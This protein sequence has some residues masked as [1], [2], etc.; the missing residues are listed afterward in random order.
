MTL[1]ISDHLKL[2]LGAVTEPLA[3]VARRGRGK[4]YAGSVLA[5]EMLKV[6]QQVAVIDPMDVWFGLRS[7]ADGKGD[8]FPVVI[9]GGDHGD[10]AL[11]P[12]MGK[13]VADFL[14]G[15]EISAVIVPD[16]ETNQDVVDF[17]TAFLDRLLKQNREPLHLFFDEAEAFAPERPAKYETRMLGAMGRLIKRGRVRGLGAT[18]ITQRTASINKNVLSQA[19][20]L[21]IMALSSPWDRAPVEKWMASNGTP[22]QMEELKDDLASLPIGGGYFWHPDWDIFQRIKIR[23]R[24]TFDSSATPEPGQKQ[25]APKKL[26][27]IDREKV[28]RQFAQAVERAKADDPEEL[29]R[30][31]A[32][33]ERKLR[34]VPKGKT[35]TE[36]VEIPV[37][38]S[39][40]LD[41]L[42]SLVSDVEELSASFEDPLRAFSGELQELLSPLTNQLSEIGSQL[43]Q[44]KTPMAGKQGVPTGSGSPV[45]AHDQRERSALVPP[46]RSRRVSPALPPSSDEISRSQQKILDMLAWLEGVG[47]QPASK[48]QVALFVGHSPTSGGYAN[49][50]GRLRSVGLIDYP[51]PGTV[52]L[53]SEGRSRA[54]PPDIPPTT[55]ALHGQVMGLVSRSQAAILE[56]LIWAYPEA[57]S[58]QEIAERIGASPTSGGFANNLGR[59]RSLGLINYPRAGYAGAESVLFL[60]GAA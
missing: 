33:L 39:E 54:R 8:G 9:F 60:K 50:L 7:S 20:G 56:L 15:E 55:E 51:H 42:V 52:E 43:E 4:T 31:I 36:T 23:K 24:E 34:E 41:V 47:I 32:E 53:T 19:G 29:R 5:E 58:K 35:V 27:D 18:L 14:V 16:F 46:T 17:M 25:K 59:L 28:A 26:S 30:R 12:S 6:G 11:T 21:L 38:E 49:N 44:W 57:I 13:Q 22:E 2:P 45:R 10:V 3:I 37:I 48:T 40:R 1:R